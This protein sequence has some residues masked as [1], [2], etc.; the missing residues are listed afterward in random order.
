MKCILMRLGKIIKQSRLAANLTQVGIAEQVGIKRE[1]GLEPSL[2]SKIIG[3]IGG[4]KSCSCPDLSVK[5]SSH[6]KI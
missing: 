4:V 6:F 1:T 5:N 2:H 3:N